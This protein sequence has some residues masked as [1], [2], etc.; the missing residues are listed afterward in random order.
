MKLADLRSIGHNIAD[1]L[2]CGN[3]FLVGL[4]GTDIFGEARRSPERCI[5]IDFV[6]GKVVSGRASRSLAGAIA[7]Y[8][9][10]LADLCKKHGTSHTVFRELT[11]RYSGDAHGRRFVVTVEDHQG[12]RV[13]DEYVGIASRRIRILDGLGRVRRK[14]GRVLVRRRPSA[15]S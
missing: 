5:T 8:A 9:D 1:S 15:M 13:A 14:R 10:A 2:A 6:S 3:G 11:V 4:Y 7:L 12:R